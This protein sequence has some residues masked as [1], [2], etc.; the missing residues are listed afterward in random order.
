MPTD[1][2]KVIERF[3]Q[4]ADAREAELRRLV[5]FDDKVG[6]ALEMLMD[7]VWGCLAYLC[8]YVSATDGFGRW[9]DMTDLVTVSLKEH[10]HDAYKRVTGKEYVVKEMRT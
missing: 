2:S 5:A 3:N 4:L 9:H 8:N 1:M 7:E 6:P 10:L